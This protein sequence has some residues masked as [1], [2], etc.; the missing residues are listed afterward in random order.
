MFEDSHQSGRGI[1]HQNTR[2]AVD[3]QIHGMQAGLVPRFYRCRAVGGQRF[4]PHDDSFEL[5]RLTVHFY[6]RNPLFGRHHPAVGQDGDIRRVAAAAKGF[7]AHAPLAPGK[8]QVSV[9][10]EGLD[11]VLPGLTTRSNPSGAMAT[12]K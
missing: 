9:E 11:L 10:G 6:S 2:V 5:A 7:D 12:S 8:L 3:G 4:R 1:K